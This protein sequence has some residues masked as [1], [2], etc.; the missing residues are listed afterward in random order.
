LFL[1]RSLVERRLQQLTA[2]LNLDY[3]RALAW[4]FAQAVLSAIWKIEDGLTLDPT[5][6]ILKIGK[7]HST[8]VAEPLLILNRANRP[9]SV[10]KGRGELWRKQTQLS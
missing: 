10:S 5:D 3:E 9:A 6:P 4:S 2:K 7:Y 1:S 8:A